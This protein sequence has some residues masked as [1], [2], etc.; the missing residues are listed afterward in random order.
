[1]LKEFFVDH[2]RVLI[3]DTR[4]ELGVLA[5]KETA[6]YLT[7]FLSVNNRCNVIFAAAPSQNEFLD[8]LSRNKEINWSKIQ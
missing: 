8:H 1:M 3:C 6:A 4:E 2:L 7:E 5:A